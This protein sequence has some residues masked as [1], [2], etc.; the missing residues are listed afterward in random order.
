MLMSLSKLVD[1]LSEGIHNNKCLDCESC[2]DYIKTKNEKLILK[3]FNCKQYYEKGF[4]KELVKRFA[5][6]YEFCNKDLN[7]FILLLRKGVYPYEY[8]DN[9]EGFNETSLPHKESF[10]MTAT[11]SKEFLDIQATIECGFTCVRD[12]IRTYS[13]M[14]RTDKYSQHSSIVWPVWLNG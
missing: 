5:S 9:L 6:T 1:N 10:Y 12:M 2:L 8:M 7:K 3:C 11:S 13:Q 14:H 4:N